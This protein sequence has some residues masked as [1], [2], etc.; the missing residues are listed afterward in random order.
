MKFVKRQFFFTWNRG[1]EKVM[2]KKKKLITKTIDIF[3]YVYPIC[4]I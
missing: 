3:K 4:K 1:P 2:T